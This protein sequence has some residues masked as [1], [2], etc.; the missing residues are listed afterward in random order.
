LNSYILKAEL[1]RER[2]RREDN[3]NDF[4]VRRLEDVGENNSDFAPLVLLPDG[5]GINVL[6]I[7]MID[8]IKEHDGVY[9]FDIWFAN[10]MHRVSFVGE[11]GMTSSPESV[12]RQCRTELLKIWGSM[13]IISNERY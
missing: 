6:K 8:T 10:S 9:S 3:M 2:E 13:I 1:K 12:A 11:L 5:T 7:V 4:N